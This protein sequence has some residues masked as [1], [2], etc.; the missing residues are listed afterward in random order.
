MSENPLPNEPLW[1]RI[2]NAPT[3][4]LDSLDTPE[5]MAKMD[6]FGKSPLVESLVEKYSKGPIEK[7]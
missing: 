4:F 2:L 3:R 6:E 7:G 1:K 5:S